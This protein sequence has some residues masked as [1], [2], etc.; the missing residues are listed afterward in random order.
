MKSVHK[1]FV[2]FVLHKQLAANFDTAD[3]DGNG[4]VTRQEAMAFEKA[5]RQASAANNA[6]ASNSTSGRDALQQ[7]LQTMMRMYNITGASQTTSS[8]NTAA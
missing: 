8:I 3:A 5:Q 4:K 6:A 2:L 1:Q 7:Q